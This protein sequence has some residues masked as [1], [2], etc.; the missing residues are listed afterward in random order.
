TGMVVGTAAYMAPE[1]VM[2]R[3]VGPAAD[4]YSLGLVL[5]ECLTGQQEYS[6]ASAEAAVARLGRSP[7]IPPHTPE[8]LRS[9][10]AEMTAMDPAHRPTA[11]TVA[12]RLSGTATGGMAAGGM[13]GGGPATGT[14]TVPYGYAAQPPMGGTAMMPGAQQQPQGSMSSTQIMPGAA[15]G[16]VAAA[17]GAGRGAPGGTMPIRPAGGGRPPSGAG[18]PGSGGS[19]GSSWL[20]VLAVVVA[21]A[22]VAFGG[23]KL[24]TSFGTG[25]GDSPNTTPTQGASIPP[26][27]ADQSPPDVTPSPER[28]LAPT[29]APPPTY[30]P[31][32]PSKPSPSFSPPYSPP[33]SAQTSP[34]ASASPAPPGGTEGQGQGSLPIPSGS[35]LPGRIAHGR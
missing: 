5:L 29:K 31:P 7:V 28:S 27:T 33:P 18:G 15:L 23:Y 34:E 1:Q 6:G 30:A 16:G 11:A 26:V 4:V 21:L 20:K 14:A 25:S 12:A 10:L 2:G 19:G 13:L 9:V 35:F 24:A 8:P 3:T 22:A 32:S 17:A